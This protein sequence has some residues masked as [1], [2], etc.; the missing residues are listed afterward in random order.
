MRI[1]E[2]FSRVGTRDG[3]RFKAKRPSHSMGATASLLEY[4]E[5]RTPDCIFISCLLVCH[6]A[7][8]ASGQMNYIYFYVK[9][10]VAEDHPSAIGVSFH[11]SAPIE[12]LIPP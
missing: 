3:R 9:G 5:P 1:K 8:G 10:S 6:G 7:D 11:S 12:P 4:C 2:I